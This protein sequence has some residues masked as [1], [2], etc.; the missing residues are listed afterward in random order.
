MATREIFASGDSENKPQID[1]QDLT[2]GGYIETA[3]Q[4][5]PETG[6]RTTNVE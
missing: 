2:D 5:D 1:R 4:I 3:V 6:T